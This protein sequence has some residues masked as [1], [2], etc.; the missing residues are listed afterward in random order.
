MILDGIL[1]TGINLL[2][3]GRTINLAEFKVEV[4]L[5]M[6]MSPMLVFVSYKL[7]IE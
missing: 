6:L 2:I 5:L 7:G 3:I 4:A 1:K